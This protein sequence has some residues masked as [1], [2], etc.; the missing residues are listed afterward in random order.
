MPL[1]H[2]CYI[3]SH[4]DELKRGYY[5]STCSCHLTASCCNISTN[6]ASSFLDPSWLVYCYIHGYT[7]LEW[8]WSVSY[9][10][11]QRFWFIWQRLLWQW[12]F[13]Q[14]LLREWYQQPIFCHRRVR[15]LF[16]QGRSCH[17]NCRSSRS[18]LGSGWCN[19]C[20]VPLREKQRNLFR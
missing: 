20:C 19:F 9:A 12:L 7:H 4:P 11:Q 6:R 8:L 17:G 14:W 1:E 10:C 18:E 15:E 13:R 3:L 2:P 5:G 16:Q